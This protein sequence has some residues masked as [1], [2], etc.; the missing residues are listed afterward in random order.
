MRGQCDFCYYRYKYKYSRLYLSSCVTVA[1]VNTTAVVTSSNLSNKHTMM[2][3]MKERQSRSIPTKSIATTINIT[4][5]SI[6]ASCIFKELRPSLILQALSFPPST[7]DTDMIAADTMCTKYCDFTAVS[8]NER[9]KEKRDRNHFF[10]SYKNVRTI[11]SDGAD[12]KMMNGDCPLH[13]VP[14][15]FKILSY[16]MK[17]DVETMKKSMRRIVIKKKTSYVSPSRIKNQLRKLL[18]KS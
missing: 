14:N 10:R 8:S 5:T 4:G 6:V 11:C 12:D 3:S 16:M 1:I 17:A 13:P 18:F 7:Q 2:I 9:Q 15:G